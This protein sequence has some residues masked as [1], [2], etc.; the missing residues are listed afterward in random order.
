VRCRIANTDGQGA[1][2]RP[3]PDTAGAPIQALAEGTL[4]ACDDYAWRRITLPN[5]TQGWIANEFLA[6]VDGGFKVANTDD[7]GANVRVQPDTTADRVTALPEDAVVQ[8]E[9]HAWRRTT[10]LAGVQ[11]WVAE[12]FLAYLDT[13]IWTFEIG[14]ACSR[15]NYWDPSGQPN[16]EAAMLR[17][18]Q[19]PLDRRRAVFEAALDAALDA[20][21]M[22][23]PSVRDQWKLAMRTIT[24]GSGFPGECPDLN[25]FML[26]GEVGGVFRGGA[27]Y[28]NSSALGYFQFIAQKP[29][30][31]G[32]PFSSQ[33]DYGH[34]SSYGPCE[35]YAHQTDPVSQVRQFIR[36]IQRSAKHKGDPMSVVREKSTPPHVWGP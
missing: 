16:R 9:A 14:V 25:P 7:R 8:G 26:A 22:H 20:E 34:W 10:T 5:G 29:I 18:N 21:G 4:V 1:N 13:D 24:L 6:G 3:Q 23:D 32:T 27:D 17:V 36:A 2:L 15:E 12:E 33:Y 35:D 31:V 19:I 28:L 30:P 11:G